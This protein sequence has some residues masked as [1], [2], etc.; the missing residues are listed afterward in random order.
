M[1]IYSNTQICGSDHQIKVRD[2]DKTTWIT[3]EAGGQRIVMEAEHVQALADALDAHK[4]KSTAL[5]AA[6]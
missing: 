6:E 3:I 5:E 1:S 2:D 4:L